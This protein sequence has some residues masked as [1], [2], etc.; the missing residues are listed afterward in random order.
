MK[1]RN[2]LLLNVLLVLA[3]LSVVTYNVVKVD[4]YMHYHAPL[5][6]EYYYALGM[7]RYINN[8]I[9]K[10]FEYDA[11]IS[12]TSMIENFKTSEFDE[13]FSANS[14]KLPYQGATYKEIN[15]NLLIAAEKNPE[16]CLV[17]RCLDYAKLF[18]PSDML[19]EDLGSY[20]DYLYDDNIFNDYEY[21]F[22]KTVIFSRVYAMQKESRSE[23]FEPGVTSFDT[24]SNW[25]GV[26]SFGFDS[27]YPDAQPDFAAVGEPVHITEAEAEMV[28]QSIRENVCSLARDYPG[29][30]LY[31]FFSPYSAAWWQERQADGTLYKF[32]EAEQIAIEEMLK[33]DNINLFS[34]NCLTEMTTDLNNYKDVTHYGDWV[35]SQILKWMY[36]GDYQLTE[37][38]YREYLKEELEFYSSY[39]YSLLAQQEDYKDDSLAAAEFEKLVK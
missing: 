19:R 5:T 9:T 3:L 37:E 33:Y 39:D 15:E 38:N 1:G 31:C 30:T 26:G 25:M 10:N 23:G 27:I 32:I 14:V 12:G 35:N 22:N 24:Y 18:D 7:Q 21:V 34:F 36:A 17:L 11:V 8:G 29:I 13:V 6:D 4:P 2:W 20:P 28:A 16:L